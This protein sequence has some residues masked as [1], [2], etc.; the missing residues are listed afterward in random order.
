MI[1]SVEDVYTSYL[2]Q[3][4]VDD[5]IDPDVVEATLRRLGHSTPSINSILGHG[6]RRRHTGSSGS[7]VGSSTTSTGTPN[8]AI[9]AAVT[10][11]QVH[12]AEEEGE[13]VAALPPP[14]P[15]PPPVPPS[16]FDGSSPAS[17]ERGEVY[18]DHL[19]TVLA[20]LQR[21][22]W[23]IG[24]EGEDGGGV[25]HRRA[26]HDSSSGLHKNKAHTPPEAAED[27]RSTNNTSSSHSSSSP[28]DS[29]ASTSE[30]VTDETTTTTATTAPDDSYWPSLSGADDGGRW[31]RGAWEETPAR[32][33]HAS[34]Q[35]QQQ[36][37]QQR[38]YRDSSLPPPLPPPP[39]PHAH[40]HHC[41]HRPH[42]WL[43][44]VV[45]S[46]PGG[47]HHRTPYTNNNAYSNEHDPVSPFMAARRQQ[48][49]QQE[50]WHAGTAFIRSRSPHGTATRTTIEAVAAVARRRPASAAGRF[51]GRS[52]SREPVGS[53][54][55][56]QRG[57]VRL[58]CSGGGRGGGCCYC[59]HCGPSYQ[60]G[61]ATTATATS[62]SA[63]QRQTTSVAAAQVHTVGATAGHR[64]STTATAAV[65]PSTLPL[66]R[67]TDRVR[68]AQQY[69]REWEQRESAA[70]AAKSRAVWATRCQ[71]L[72]GGGE[73]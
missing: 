16:L 55:Q 36:Q 71:L 66:G 22:Q 25:G 34:R 7:S 12:A 60:F 19:A 39:L 57:T 5:G 32:Y 18:S 33:R 3:V 27:R 59:R 41:H 52:I 56:R 54:P 65:L 70:A 63:Q 40:H 13:V 62:T 67:R 28:G 50:A 35:R 73:C 38:R 24:K 46:R 58:G 9:I 1:A 51:D 23:A 64:S 37:R 69:L 47:R 44:D 6:S 48:Q 2:Q 72:G 15:R 30:P 53:P 42:A 17:V 21:L 4:C 45:L 68:L 10:P 8:A 43:D 20:L 26:P 31:E 14:R 11:P 49:R 29:S 61:F